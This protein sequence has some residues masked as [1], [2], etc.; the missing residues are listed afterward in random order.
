MVRLDLLKSSAEGHR[1]V[2]E[3]RTHPARK[4]ASACAKSS[5]CRYVLRCG[6]RCGPGR[7]ARIDRLPKLLHR[8]KADRCESA[9]CVE[10]LVG[11]LEQA[12]YAFPLALDPVVG[13]LG[14]R[15][16][17]AGSN[18][19]LYAVREAEGTATIERSTARGSR[20]WRVALQRLWRGWA[21]IAIFGSWAATPSWRPCFLATWL[22]ISS[23]RWR[24]CFWARASRCSRKPSRCV[25][26][27]LRWSANTASSSSRCIHAEAGCGTRALFNLLNF[28]QLVKVRHTRR[29]PPARGV[30]CA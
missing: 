19:V 10:R 15:W 14:Y 12:P 4:G 5:G 25:A 7:L 18:I 27:N 24:P 17:R 20:Q 1:D 11:L 9:R 3:G 23:S 2:V 30:L 22:I 21:H 13:L 29:L 26:S 6:N 8:R 28:V 16:A